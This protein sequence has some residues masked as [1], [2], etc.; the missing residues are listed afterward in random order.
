MAEIKTYT[1]EDMKF[2]NLSKNPLTLVDFWAT[3]CGPCRMMGEKI[4]NELLPAAPDVKVVK[5]NVDEAPELV[6][7]IGIVSVPTLF[8]YRDGVRRAVF[9]GVKPVDKLLSALG[10]G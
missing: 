3:W 7:E 9:V 6:A 4:D 2:E 1:S 5:V 10:V 8:C